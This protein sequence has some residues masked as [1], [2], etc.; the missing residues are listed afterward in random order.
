MSLFS[1]ANE[2]TGLQSDYFMK[3]GK[4]GK[5][6]SRTVLYRKTVYG[7]RVVRAKPYF[8]ESDSKIMEDIIE[9]RKSAFE[10]LSK[11]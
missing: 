6:K 7:R 2:F 8:K 4:A 11:Y 1:S 5:T 10:K 3:S 9:R